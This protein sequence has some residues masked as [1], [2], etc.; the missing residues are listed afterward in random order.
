MSTEQIFREALRD[1]ATGMHSDGISRQRAVRALAQA[2][3]P[4]ICN[5]CGQPVQEDQV[6]MYG[7]HSTCYFTRYRNLRKKGIKKP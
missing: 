1:I 4:L 7:S 5:E 6:S 2:G 3:E